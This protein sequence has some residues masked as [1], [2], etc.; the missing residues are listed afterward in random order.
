LFSIGVDDIGETLGRVTAQ[1]GSI[2][3]GPNDTP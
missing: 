1:G 2:R 3:G